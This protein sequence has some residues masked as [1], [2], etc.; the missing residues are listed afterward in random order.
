LTSR[1]P[2]VLLGALIAFIGGMLLAP[3]FEYGI[4]RIFPGVIPPKEKIQITT[5]LQP[6]QNKRTLNLLQGQLTISKNAIDAQEQKTLAIEDILSQM[7]EDILF[8]RAE[9]LTH[10]KQK[11]NLPLGEI[12]EAPDNLDIID[13]YESRLKNLEDKISNLQVG[14]KDPSIEGKAIEKLGASVQYIDQLGAIEDRLQLMENRPYEDNKY[15]PLPILLANLARRV[16][17]GQV[18][19]EELLNVRANFESL[20]V[21]DRAK[22]K[23]PFNMLSSI[24]ASGVLSEEDLKLS[25]SKLIS[26]SLRANNL[27]D[28]AGYWQKTKNW[29]FN[30]IVVRKTGNIQG[31]DDEALI[32]RAEIS[33]GEKNIEKTVKIVEA[34]STSAKGVMKP[35]IEDAKMRVNAIS[36][37]DSLIP[38]VFNEAQS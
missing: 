3:W 21:L 17:G 23:S 14:I 10:N 6:K 11:E 18:F 38:I 31:D 27:S 25:F 28:D 29:F 24:A 5:D 15:S 26:T 36:A 34:L 35:W 20:S 37:I 7:N 9:F 12:L 32:A 30:L 16:D 19:E 22:A 1:M 2:W 33:L 8:L 13:L 4:G